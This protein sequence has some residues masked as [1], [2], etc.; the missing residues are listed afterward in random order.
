MK[1]IAIVAL[2]LVSASSL[3]GCMTTRSYVDPTYR[4]ATL[5]SIQRPAQPMPVK[6][7]VQFLRNG[8]RL[9]A[10]DFEVRDAV[11]RTLTR[12]GVFT[13][14]TADTQATISVSANNIA[15]L[16]AARKAGFKTGLT[17]GGAGSTVQDNYEFA[18]SYQGAAGAKKE[19]AYQHTLH[20][21]IGNADAPAGMTPTTPA[22]GFVQI[23]EDVVLNFVKDLQDAGTIPRQ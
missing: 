13:P 15:D 19:L 5:E 9:P 3:M 10:V 22:A 17:F 1:R 4:K 8:Q 2:L 7:D 18:C 6:V 16:A 20:T 12:T 11:E 21:T 14:A 23:V